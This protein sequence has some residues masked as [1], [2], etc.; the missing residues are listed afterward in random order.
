MFEKM[1]DHIMKALFLIVCL[2]FVGCSTINFTPAS[3]TAFPSFHGDIAVLDR[4]PE[5]YQEVGWV[6][7]DVMPQVPAGEMISMARRLAGEKG[8]NAI[9]FTNDSFRV[10][11]PSGS[12]SLLCRAIIQDR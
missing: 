10:V 11:S 6:S 1:E 2:L 8:A 7:C 5:S 4:L 12:K 9:I 3:S